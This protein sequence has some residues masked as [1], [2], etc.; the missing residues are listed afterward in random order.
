MFKYHKNIKTKMAL[1]SAVTLGSASA[2]AQTAPTTP[3]DIITAYTSGY[4]NDASDVLMAGAGLVIGGLV[5]FKLVNLAI[6]FFR[7]R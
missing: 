7:G 3:V 1:I 4:L 2:F 5:V 6:S